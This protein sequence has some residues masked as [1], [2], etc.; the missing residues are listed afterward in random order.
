MTA[1]PKRRWDDIKWESILL[2]I[3]EELGR[4]LSA[5]EREQFDKLRPGVEQMTDEIV[6]EARRAREASPLVVFMRKLMRRQGTSMPDFE[7]LYKKKAELDR[8]LSDP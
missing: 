3:E 2:G 5:D 1:T 6:S 8:K 4:P 7:A